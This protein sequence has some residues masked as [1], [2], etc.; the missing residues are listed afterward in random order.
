R[1]LMAECTDVQLIERDDTAIGQSQGR[2]VGSRLDIAGIQCRCKCCR[3][4]GCRGKELYSDTNSNQQCRCGG[5]VPPTGCTAAVNADMRADVTE[6]FTHFLLEG[7]AI[8]LLVHGVV[9]LLDNF[10]F[11]I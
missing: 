4:L 3:G 1:A 9:P 10:L 7:V 8:L 5:V 6:V 2:L 11:G